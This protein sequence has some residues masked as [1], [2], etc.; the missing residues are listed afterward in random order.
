MPNEQKN[1]KKYIDTD[2]NP[3]NQIGS[4]VPTRL[5]QLS[6]NYTGVRMNVVESKKVADGQKR[7]ITE[8]DV[9]KLLDRIN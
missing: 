2:G 8:K 1:L 4:F 5:G 9:D 6:K 7:D 3:N